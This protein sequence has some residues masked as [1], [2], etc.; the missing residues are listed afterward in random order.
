M[1]PT[2]TQD[3]SQSRAGRVVAGL[4]GKGWHDVTVPVRTGMVHYPGDPPVQLDFTKDIERGDPVTLSHMSLGV[5]TGT[6]VDA[7]LHFIPKT[8]G[9]D[10]IPIETLI[11]AARL[12]DVPDAEAVTADLLAPHEIGSGER[13]LIRT[14]NSQRCWKTDEFVA[15]YSYLTV[16]AAEL[17][18]QERVRL[19]GVD[20]LSVGRG[21]T[22][23]EVHRALLGAGIVILEGLDLS[24]LSPGLHD[25]ICLPLKLVDRDGSPARALLRPR[26][27]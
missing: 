4:D 12:I 18:A 11:G 15:D 20:Y 24:K 25:L 10:R 5:H 2:H 21:E 7:P 13:I 17:L 14:R 23:P 3:V 16:D 19:V 1:S 9:V 8:P 6:H 26:A 27:A 22:N